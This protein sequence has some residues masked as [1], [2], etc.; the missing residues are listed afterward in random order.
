[1]HRSLV[2]PLLLALPA[3]L[4]GQDPGT[5]VRPFDQKH[6]GSPNVHS[7]AHVVNHP[8]AWKAAP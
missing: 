1:M 3:S 5:A 8:G 4:P 7:V 6:G 2:I